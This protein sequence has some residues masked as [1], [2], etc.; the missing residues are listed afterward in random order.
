MAK[1]SSN[2]K[3][4]W[5]H[6]SKL[7]VFGSLMQDIPMGDKSPEEITRTLVNFMIYIPLL[8]AGIYSFAQLYEFTYPPPPKKESD[9][10]NS[11]RTMLKEKYDEESKEFADI[12]G[13]VWNSISF[14]FKPIYYIIA[15]FKNIFTWVFENPFR[16]LMVIVLTLYLAG[17]FYFTSLYKTHFILKKWSGYTNTI[18]IVLGVLLSIAVFTLFINIKPDPNGKKKE[19]DVAFIKWKPSGWEEEGKGNWVKKEGSW[20]TYK[21]ASFVAL[22]KKGKAARSQSASRHKEVAQMEKQLKEETKKLDQ[23]KRQWDAERKENPSFTSEPSAFNVNAVHEQPYRDKQAEVNKL[24]MNV[25]SLKQKLKLAKAK[26]GAANQESF[27]SKLWWMLKQALVYYKSLLLIGIIVCLPLFILWLVNH[28]S[29]L[30]TSTSIIVGV[31][32]ALALLYLIHDEFRGVG[33]VNTDGWKAFGL[34]S[35]DLS[36]KKVQ[37]E[38]KRVVRAEKGKRRFVD[39]IRQKRL[40]KIWEKDKSEL[41]EEITNK[42]K[43][44]QKMK[45]NIMNIRAQIHIGKGDQPVMKL[46]P[47]TNKLAPGRTTYKQEE[48]VAEKKLA[49]M[50]KNT[51]K[52]MDKYKQYQSY[53]AWWKDEEEKRKQRGEK[54]PTA[55][56]GGFKAEIQSG[57]GNI[58]DVQPNNY[59]KAGEDKDNLYNDVLKRVMIEEGHSNATTSDKQRAH[60]ITEIIKKTWT[61]TEMRDPNTKKRFIRYEEPKKGG[62]SLLTKIF[63]LIANIPWLLKDMICTICEFCGMK[64]PKGLLI[65]LLIEVIFIVLYF[66]I[67]LIP[68]FLYTHSVSKHDDLL[69]Q[70]SELAS[71][72]EIIQK[73]KYLEQLIN[74]MSIDWETVL[75]DGLYKPNM[76]AVLIEYLKKRGYQP[77]NEMNQKKGF[78]ASMYARAVTPPLSLE[79]AVTYVQTNGPV[80]ISLRNQIKMLNAAHYDS[81]KKKKDKDNILKTKILLEGPIYTD[82]ERV[83]S[84]YKDLGS[85]VGTFNYNYAISAWFFI[86]NQ[87]PSH[88]IANTKFTSILNYANRPNILFNVEK[89]TLRIT[90][91]NAIDKQQIIYETDDFPLQKWNNIVVNYNGGTLDIFIN[92]TLV[93]STSNVVPFMTYDAITAG[94]NNGVSGGIC[95]VTYFPT[96]LTLSKIKVFY[97]SLKSKNPPI[98]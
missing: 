38:K 94:T 10:D 15:I 14:L 16:T 4:L 87:P 80:I 50:K 6:L 8:I 77:A 79:A 60:S 18:M 39:N 65:I 63:K 9:K 11:F 28:F 21:P 51:N 86:H 97:K 24:E 89:N 90:M 25:A 7:P 45:S 71:E 12:F 85:A 70:Q 27:L 93:S 23:L 47:L 48:K 35:A 52:L 82:S 56:G 69:E 92:A 26:E 17:S 53:A 3:G 62:D 22:E 1:S 54:F 13:P 84:Q 66:V 76:E 41:A 30:S 42:Q 20:K 43:E 73:D 19:G 72:K 37:H 83:I 31:I 5:H 36:L 59:A 40:R 33:D 32:S 57:G 61:K 81:T 67:P 29:F 2:S 78:F 64:N 74:G 98:V 88:R 44:M 96:P 46:N 49:A 68:P 75:S 95:N 58:I 34:G 55:R 91:D